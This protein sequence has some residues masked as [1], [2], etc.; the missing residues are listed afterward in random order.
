MSRHLLSVAV[1]IFM[2]HAGTAF[3]VEP[4]AAAPRTTGQ[5]NFDDL[6]PT[7]GD[8]PAKPLEFT[9]VDGS[10]INITIHGPALTVTDL[11]QF[12]HLDAIRG[13]A[14][15]TNIWPQQ[16]G[17]SI[18][19]SRPVRMVSVIAGDFGGDDDGPLVLRAFDCKGRVVQESS[20]PWKDGQMPPFAPL[21]VS[22]DSI[23]QVIFTSGGEFAGSAFLDR[24]EFSVGSLKS[25]RSQ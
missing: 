19:F 2:L 22:A 12:A 7:L 5:L 14:L 24:L 25:R 20:A 16:D 4:D 18:K 9:D 15:I 23:C 21:R 3:A 11:F 17:I 13:N 8:P 10:G 1:T 6:Q